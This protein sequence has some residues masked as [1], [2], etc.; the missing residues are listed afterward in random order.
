MKPQSAKG[1]GRRFQQRIV[2]SILETFPDLQ[3]DDVLSTSMGCGGEDVRLSPFARRHLPLSL[4]AKCQERLNVWAALEQAK[5]NCPS[6]STPCVVFSKNR[7]PTYA[8]L[9]WATVLD[10]FRELH[11]ARAGR[12][13]VRG[14]SDSSE[15]EC[16]AGTLPADLV[17]L[18]RQLGRFV[19]PADEEELERRMAYPGT[20]DEEEEDGP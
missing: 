5:S 12:G 1:K 18:L 10:L 8:V 19:P 3:P 4:E 7:A 11:A 14:S 16:T 20:L 15:E 13:P 2:A 6:S 17:G 9:P